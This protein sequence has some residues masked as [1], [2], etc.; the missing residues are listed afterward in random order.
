MKII[1]Q[2]EPFV[3]LTW[4][5]KGDMPQ[6]KAMKIQKTMIELND[7]EAGKAILKAA[8]VEKFVSVSDKDYNKVREI[9]KYATGEDY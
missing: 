3:H 2:S 6:D 4:A 1:A 5:V 8:L 7:S 9:T